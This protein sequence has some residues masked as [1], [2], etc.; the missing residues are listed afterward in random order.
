MK[1]RRVRVPGG[2]Y[3]F[4]VVT[5]D[6]RP[7]LCETENID[8]LR[9]A[10]RHVMAAH[11]FTIDA[12]AILPDHIHSIWTLPSADSNF[13]TRWRLVKSYFTRHCQQQ[14]H[15][16]ISASRFDKQ[17][18]AVWQRRFWEHQIKD[19]RDFTH[20]FDYIHYNP[21]KHGLVAAPKDWQSSSFHHHVRAGIYNL[22]WGSSSLRS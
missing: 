13:S 2:T 8:L 16:E 12:I 9:N 14:Y 3:F 17:E 18:Q 4:T 6:R 20:H 7:F 11:P 21:V 10:F 19:E 22:N 5:H 1:Y 15:G